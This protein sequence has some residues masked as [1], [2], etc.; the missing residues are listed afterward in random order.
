LWQRVGCGS[1]NLFR[2]DFRRIA[3]PVVLVQVLFRLWCCLNLS[4][5]L[6]PPIFFAPESPD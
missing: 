6:K 4:Q 2:D 1:K 5:G 3:M